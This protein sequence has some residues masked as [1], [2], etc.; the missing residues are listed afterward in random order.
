MHIFAALVPELDAGGGFV[1]AFIFREAD[2]SVYTKE[3]T[4]GPPGIGHIVRADFGQTYAKIGDELKQRFPHVSFVALSVCLKPV[5]IVVFFKL[6]KEG[7][8]F[9]GDVPCLGHR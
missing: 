6:P 9:R 7:E 5:P 2:I 1:R 4:A 8:K 3:R